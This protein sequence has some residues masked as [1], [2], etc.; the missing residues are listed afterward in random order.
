MKDIRVPGIVWAIGI[1][2]VVGLIHSN[3]F[4]IQQSTGIQPWLLDI[5][6][7]ALIGVL[8]TLNLG[9]DQLNQALDIIDRLLL[10]KRTEPG[11]QM[12]GDIE[13][14]ELVTPLEIPDRPNPVARWLVG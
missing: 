8:K 14:R 11:V 2:V 13:S 1:I 4:Y 5:G 6:V 10:E 9:T 12:R 7:A 3:A